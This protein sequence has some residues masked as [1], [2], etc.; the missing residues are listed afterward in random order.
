MN[1]NFQRSLAAVLKDEGGNDDDPD[2]HGGRT[3]RGITQREYTACLTEYKRP[4]ADVWTASQTDIDQIYY[5]EYWLPECATLPIG[6]DFQFFSMKVN[7]GPNRAIILLQQS[8]NVIA[9]G[10]IGPVTRQKL[11]TCDHHRLID[12]FCAD[13]IIFYQNLHQPKFLRGWINRANADRALALLM[14]EGK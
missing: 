5:D 1:T 8:L 6:V 2:D 3:S 10:R 9:D 4:N 13:S 7:A 14:L 12:T 11:L